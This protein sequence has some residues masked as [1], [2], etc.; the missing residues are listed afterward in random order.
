M[1]RYLRAPPVTKSGGVKGRYT[2]AS[3]YEISDHH[4]KEIGHITPTGGGLNDGVSSADTAS[5]STSSTAA[6]T[7]SKKVFSGAARSPDVV[8]GARGANARG[9]TTSSKETSVTQLS[10]KGSAIVQSAALMSS[11]DLQ[12]WKPVIDPKILIML[13]NMV[14]SADMSLIASCMKAFER[15][16]GFRPSDLG[17]LGLCQAA[18]FSLTLPIWG[19]ALPKYGCRTLLSLACWVWMITTF[20]TPMGH[21]LAMQACLR[22]LN[23]AA[24]SGVMPVSQAVLADIVDEDQR[25]QAFGWVGA[26]H[27]V[28][29][30]IVTYYVLA[31]GENWAQCFYLV[32][33]ATFLLII[34]LYTQL[35]DS[36]GKQTQM[37]DSVTGEPISFGE[38]AIRAAKRILQIPSFM[39]LVAQGVVG[40]TPWQAMS[41]LNMY[42]LTL[43]FSNTEAATIAA[44]INSGGILGC[45]LGGTMGDFF[46]RNVSSDRGRVMVAQLSVLLGIPC[47]CAMLSSTLVDGSSVFMAC[48]CGFSFYLL[49]TWCSFAANRPICTELVSSS[50][51]RAQIVGLW[52]LIEGTFGALFGAPVV[53]F[54]S[55]AFGYRLSKD[56]LASGHSATAAETS[57]Y[58][59]QEKK[60]AAALSSALT[61]LGVICW[62][63]CLLI[64]SVMYLT[65]PADRANARRLEQ[66]ERRRQEE[67]LG[68]E[69][70]ELGMPLDFDTGTG[71]EDAHETRPL[72]AGN[73]H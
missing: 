68:I 55:E 71:D 43:G 40:G 24:L 27:S 38:Q 29:K 10:S 18:S 9:G 41:F 2:Q 5:N 45:L 7:A 52:V 25:G 14:D 56:V 70:D 33:F 35:P 44:V 12:K 58:N 11:R 63:L 39:V 49:A 28:A 36:Y 65:F 66:E 37:V 19:A 6:S 54:V 50:A 73:R 1:E 48:L 16:F 51:D 59:Q 4:S 30:V 21:T 57:A 67:E 60:N 46:A 15:D 53:G 32:G 34:L 72:G 8:Y 47:W 17:I 23:G 31:M 42:W 61:G 64:W 13:V 62:T 22:I 20:L 69:G 3:G 26:L